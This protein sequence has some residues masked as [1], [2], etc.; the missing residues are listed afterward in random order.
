MNYRMASLV[1]LGCAFVGDASEMRA[2]APEAPVLPM[3]IKFRHVPQYF[4]QS[5]T[6]DPRYARIE[7]LVD[8]GRCDVILLDKTTN[9]EAF[10]STSILGVDVLAANGVDAY[11]TQIDL[12][13]SSTAESYPL[14]T[15]HFYDQFGQELTW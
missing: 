8:E 4:E 10:Y 12:T 9:R 15:I 14:F 2:Q 1:L 5:F 3:E 11:T 13:T 6:D 7:A